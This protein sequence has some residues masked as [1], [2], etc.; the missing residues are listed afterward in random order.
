MY[1][2][3]LVRI[4]ISLLHDSFVGTWLVR[5]WT[6]WVLSRTDESC[7]TYEYVMSHLQRSFVPYTNASCPTYNTT[8]P[9]YERVVSHVQ[10]RHVPHTNE[11][12][13]TYKWVLSRTHT[14]GSCPMCKYHIHIQMNHVPHTNK[15]RPT[16][17][18]VKSYTQKWVM[19]HIHR[20]IGQTNT[21]QM[22]HVPHTQIHRNGLCGT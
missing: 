5:L 11:S 8:C 1:E 12:C 3:W 21:C 2:T 7:P 16:Y 18:W 20:R 6:C 10:M 9:T 19:C 13:P 22:G 14:N 17:K 15:S 4:R